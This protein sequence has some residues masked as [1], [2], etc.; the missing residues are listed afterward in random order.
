VRNEEEEVVGRMDKEIGGFT[1][2][3]HA[4]LNLACEPIKVRQREKRERGDSGESQREREREREERERERRKV[5][6]HVEI[7]LLRCG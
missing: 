5:G 4:P 2:P 1:Q 7:A 3:A 6:T